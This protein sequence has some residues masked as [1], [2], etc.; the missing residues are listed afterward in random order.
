MQ[1]MLF[2]APPITSW[3]ASVLTTLQGRPSFQGIATGFT[4]HAEII[5]GWRMRIACSYLK[6]REHFSWGLWRG[7]AGRCSASDCSLVKMQ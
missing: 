4:E 6:L 5:H 3:C 2:G 7:A 1:F